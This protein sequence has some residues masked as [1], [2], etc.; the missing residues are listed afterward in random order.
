MDGDESVRCFFFGVACFVIKTHQVT[1]PCSSLATCNPCVPPRRLLERSGAI[2][3]H[4]SVF[5][6]F[7]V[8]VKGVL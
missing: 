3:H 6:L 8:G 4:F 2:M 5:W 1:C 7:S